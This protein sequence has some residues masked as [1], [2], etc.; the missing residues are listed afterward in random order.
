MEMESFFWED[1]TSREGV[2]SFLFETDLEDASLQFS[3]TV[4]VT[5]LGFR[6]SLQ[7]FH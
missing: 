1:A 5:V 4:P 3:L 7:R 6:G 2:R